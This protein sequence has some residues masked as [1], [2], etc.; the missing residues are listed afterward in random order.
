MKH[1]IY[2][3]VMLLLLAMTSCGSD[4]STVAVPQ[5]AAELIESGKDF[6]KLSVESHNAESG[7]YLCLPATDR[8]PTPGTIL[9]TGKPLASV[10]D[11][12]EVRID[13]LKPNTDY[14]VY[15]AARNA[16][17]VTTTM[18]KA[19]TEKSYIYDVTMTDGWITYYGDFYKNKVGYYM[20]ALATGPI[21]QSG[22]PTQTGDCGIH[23]FIGDAVAQDS[24]NGVITPGVY[25]IS[26]AHE[27]GTV[28]A[29]N[30]RFMDVTEVENGVPTKGYT[31]KFVDGTVTV[32]HEADGTYTM[33]ADMRIERSGVEEHVRCTFKGKLPYTNVDPAR[34][35]PLAEDTKMIPK[36]MSGNYSKSSQGDYGVY[37]FAIFN[38]PV[39]AGGFINGAGELVCFTLISPYSD[40]MDLDKM[41]GTY[42]TALVPQ[43]GMTYVPY[44]YITGTYE[45][46]YGSY[47][48]QGS[49]YCLYDDAL[50]MKAIGLFVSGEI[51]VS[52]T[53]DNITLKANM[54]TVQN[55]RVTLE[56][57]APASSFVDYSSYAKPSMLVN[58]K[59]S[60]L[61]KAM[62]VRK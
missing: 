56:A 23:L 16:T 9:T 57:T 45:S 25:R 7:A 30:S 33:E 37:N 26:D 14:V 4:D 29:Y 50:Q 11:K 36:S 49:F 2:G 38:T 10:N 6:V 13:G 27:A 35:N 21:S 46:Y 28:D 24:D 42:K 62:P 58:R 8:Q 15:V 41:V 53:G 48:P 34:Y 3:A 22:L 59:S 18:T 39:D 52:K 40:K 55:K 17:E 51:E 60:N 5:V 44:S 54:L 47:M 31:F 43:A 12:Q 32:G 1:L 19:S 20:V 61:P